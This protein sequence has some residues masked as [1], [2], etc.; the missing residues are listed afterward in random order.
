[1]EMRHLGSA[2]PAVSAIGL[3]TMSL[4][5]TND[6][7]AAG[8]LLGRAL[9]AGVTLV[10]TAD[11]YGDGE[12]ESALG[13]LLASR[14]DAV[15]LATKVGL[16]MNGDPE[17]AG[18][19][20]RWIVRA[21]EDSLRRLQTDHIDLYQL[22]R[23]DPSTPIDETVAAFDELRQ[24]GKIRWAG[25]SVF[26]AEMLVE[27]QWA[28]ERQGV[29]P[30]VS[31]QS[32]Y[33]ILVRGT[34][35]AVL[36]AAQAHGVGVIAWSPLNGGWLT[37]KYRRGVAAPEGSRAASGNPFVRADDEAKLAV[38]ERLA[39]IA[40]A[41]G[42]SL[43][44]LGLGWAQEHPAISSVLV[45]PRTIEQLDQL[46]A[47]AQTRLSAATLDAIDEVVAPGTSVDPRNEGWSSPAL[48]APARR[49][50]AS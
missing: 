22:H 10:D 37:G 49:R 24:A 42:L 29:A 34:E 18:G 12:V 23:P 27:S 21:V 46:L 40:D 2:G 28:A 33:S 6:E 43:M 35:R 32:P 14:R 1:M 50:V 26:P 30:F 3:G 31:E 7:R 8:E 5:T 39:R 41:A 44:Q 20:R 4:M 38:T 17:R 47:A 25:S 13:R 19:S 16:P 36:P 11:V 9:D 48:A 15:V 45:G